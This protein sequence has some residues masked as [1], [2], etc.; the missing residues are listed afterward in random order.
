LHAIPGRDAFFSERLVE[1][2]QQLMALLGR[3]YGLIRQQ[4]GA[5]EDSEGGPLALR[6]A[7]DLPAQLPALPAGSGSRGVTTGSNIA[8]NTGVEAA[9]AQ[10]LDS[11]GK[12]VRINSKERPTDRRGADI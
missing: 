5:L 4:A 1:F 8:F 12:S 10:V 9:D 3:T 2:E 7:L 6:S 11:G